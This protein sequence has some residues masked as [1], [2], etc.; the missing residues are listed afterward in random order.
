M[1]NANHNFNANKQL[2]K[3]SLRKVEAKHKNVYHNRKIWKG[4]RKVHYV[5]LV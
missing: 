4:K 3:A 2:N 5:G 1:H